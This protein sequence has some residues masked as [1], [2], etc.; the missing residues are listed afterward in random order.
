MTQVLAPALEKIKLKVVMAMKKITHHDQLYRFKML[1]Q[2][3]KPLHIGLHYALW[4]RDPCLAEM[5]A[6]AQVQI[7]KNQGFL[8]LP[9]K[10]FFG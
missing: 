7:R 5:A 10:T 8:F 1:D 9:V 2:L 6:F 3:H 4:N